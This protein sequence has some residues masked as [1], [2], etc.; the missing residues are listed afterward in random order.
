MTNTIYSGIKG[1]IA[2]QK[3]LFTTPGHNGKVIISSKNFCKLDVASNFETDSP[4]NPTSYIL[5]SEK[6]LSDIY[7]TYASFYITNGSSCGLMAMMG[8]VLKPG[9]K[10]IVDRLCHKSVIDTIILNN[11]VPVFVNRAYNESLGFYGGFD[12]Y[13]LEKTVDE[14][15]DAKAI[16]ICSST[17]YGIAT[18]MT[19]IADI[20]HKYNIF[21][22]ADESHGAHFCFSDHFPKSA[23]SC[24]ADMVLHDA[25]ETL[26]AMSGGAILH[27][28][29]NN[30]DPYKVRK[31]I[32]TFQNPETSNAYLCALENS[33]Y[34]VNVNGKKYDTLIKEIDKS[35]ALVNDSTDIIWY[36]SEEKGE[37]FTLSNDKTRIV[38]NFGKTGISGYE[39]ANILREKH[40]IEPHFAEND[41]VILAASIFN[42]T[43]DLRKLTNAI[44]SIYR[45]FLRKHK[46][47]ITP[48]A[49]MPTIPEAT[50]FFCNPASTVRAGALTVSPAEARGKICKSTVYYHPTYI[51]VIMPGEYISDIHMQCLDM[52][53]DDGNKI[54]GLTEDMNFEIVDPAYEYTL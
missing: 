47:P 3:I 39:A 43:H 46:E 49:Y 31:T 6:Q 1:F 35:R 38:L 36:D 26:G 48:E 41:N 29:T 2:K 5:D 8:S 33:I 44:L 24:G 12:P 14:N 53:T 17:H 18:N 19:E 52:I 9:D 50:G 42:S 22:L 25:G 10:I 4:D 15:I 13:I 16:L 21:V 30:I 45:S 34:Y 20:A 11:L 27:L 40:G 28:N 54:C 32:Y 23:L 37:Y 7:R 51:P